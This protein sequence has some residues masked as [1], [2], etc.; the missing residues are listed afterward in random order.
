L[1]NGVV[2]IDICELAGVAVWTL[3]PFAAPSQRSMN[4]AAFID[5]TIDEKRRSE[6]R[7]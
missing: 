1:D 4:T 7:P 2:A 5:A 3:S 6:A